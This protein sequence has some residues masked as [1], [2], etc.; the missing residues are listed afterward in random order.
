M[1]WWKRLIRIFAP[2]LIDRLTTP[3]EP[4]QVQPERLSATQK[5]TDE[6][7]RLFIGNN[8]N[9]GATIAARPTTDAEEEEET[10]DGSR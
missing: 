8:D 9:P 3:A 7:G 10:D 2:V 5:E 4:E 6:L 1:S